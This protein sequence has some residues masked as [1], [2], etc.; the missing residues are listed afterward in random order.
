MA[1]PSN[2]DSGLPERL[3]CH[4][5]RMSRSDYRTALAIGEAEPLRGRS[6]SSP[7]NSELAAAMTTAGMAVMEERLLLVLL[8]DL[9]V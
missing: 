9:A 8:A 5:W 6:S 1:Q 2:V 7:W 4:P 3:G